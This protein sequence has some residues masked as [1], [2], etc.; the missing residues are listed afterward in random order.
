MLS[1]RGKSE[2][3]EHWVA[4]GFPKRVE[5][6]IYNGRSCLYDIKVGSQ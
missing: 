1:E 2:D 3:D 4:V 6:N 5:V